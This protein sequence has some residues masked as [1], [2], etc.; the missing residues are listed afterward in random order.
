MLKFTQFNL[1]KKQDGWLQVEDADE[2]SK[3]VVFLNKINKLQL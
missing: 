2:Y 1:R 3:K